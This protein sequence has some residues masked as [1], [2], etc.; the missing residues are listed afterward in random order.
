MLFIISAVALGLQNFGPPTAPPPDK[1]V[2]T[3]NGQAIKAKE[4]D[5]YLWDWK[6]DQV[7]Q[8]IA[9]FTLITQECKKLG[10][11][12]DPAEVKRRV[13][14]QVQQIVAT[15]PKGTSVSAALKAKGA[16]KSLIEFQNR[17]QLMLEKL[18]SKDFK[19]ENYYQVSTL[20]IRPKSETAADL[21]A[22]L[23][24]ATSAYTS[25]LKGDPW[26]KVISL[27]ATEA[28]NI[29]GHGEIGWVPV[30]QF[31]KSVQSDLSTL[32]IGGYTRPAQTNNGLQI[33]RLEAKGKDATP[34]QLTELRGRYLGSQ[35]RDLVG[36]LQKNAKIVTSY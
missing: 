7:A 11:V 4:L 35:E 13:D 27:N 22:A 34:A 16:S 24:S 28:N 18:A 17:A 15:A 29:N 8:T 6:V 20:V 32:P 33:F 1:V 21:Q 23:T 19:K 2:L 3:V 25:L 26:E 12:I 30:D 9:V 31:P 36:R 5:A 14:M 10:I